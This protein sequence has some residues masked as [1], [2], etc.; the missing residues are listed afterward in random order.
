M[1]NLP[2]YIS[3]IF[4]LTTFVTLLF[5]YKAS[6]NSKW[7][8]TGS[9]AW[10]AIQAIVASTGFYTITNSIPPRL[11]LA[12]LPPLILIAL[13]FSTY[14]GRNFIDRLDAST[15]TALHIIRV[16]VEFVL[17]WLFINK[18]VPGI[19]TF[20]GRNFDI[21]SGL[22]S[23]FVWYF[24]FVKNRLGKKILLAWNIACLLLLLNVVITA[25]LSAPFNFQ[26][27]AF[28]QPAIAI[29]YFPFIWLP[30]FVVPVVL[31]AHLVAIKRFITAFQPIK[32]E[33]A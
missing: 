13:L 33:M 11:I 6:G 19:I 9:L 28:D 8:L 30:C 15:L 4:A 7:V 22:T 20:E 32:M 3:I 18:T 5:F 10:L 24:G 23:P 14:T 26:Q 2:V 25:I 29:L 16:P 1:E 12:L 31:F 17:L 21:L 27:F